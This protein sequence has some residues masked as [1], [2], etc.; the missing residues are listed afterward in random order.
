MDEGCGN[1][2][3]AGDGDNQAPVTLDALDYA[4]GPLKDTASDAD[5]LALK[6]FAVRLVDGYE[7]VTWSGGDQHEVAHLLLVYDLRFGALGIA[8]EIKRPGAALN[9]GVEICSC[10]VNEQDIGYNRCNIGLYAV[11]FDCAPDL[12][13]VP[14]H[15]R[16]KPV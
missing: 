5:F 7:A 9:Q 2:G 6:E 1:A 13:T 11:L 4:F 16:S 3:D 12:R 10:A 14:D 15:L 8:V